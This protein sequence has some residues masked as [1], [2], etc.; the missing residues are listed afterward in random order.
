M[1]KI[2]AISGHARNGKDTTAKI[3][4]EL[5]ESNN[6]SARVVHFADFVKFVCREFFDWDGNKD[7]KGRSLLQFVGTDRVR[8]WN[9]DYW[10]DFII[11]MLNL[12]GDQWDWVIIPDTRFPNEIS[13][14]KESGFDVIHIRIQRRGFDSGLTEEQQKHASEIAL[15]NVPPD[16]QIYNDGDLEYL[17]ELVEDVYQTLK[18]HM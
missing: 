8:T 18:S 11:D 13:K 3:L 15:D 10:V 6:Q 12:F 4:K 7:E 16:I 17:K 5:I 2:L 14:I 9:P 1:A